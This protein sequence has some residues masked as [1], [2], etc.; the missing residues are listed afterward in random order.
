MDQKILRD[1][2]AKCIQ[3]EPPGCTAAC[4]VHVDARGLIKAVRKGDYAMG[5]S[6]LH[7]AVPFPR[8]ISRVCD[9]P[10]QTAC[11]RT[12]VDES[13]SVGYLERVCVEH[14]TA[15]AVKIVIPPLKSKKVAVV[16]AGL[17]GLTAA[18]ELARKGYGVTI[19]EATDRLGGSLRD[20]PEEKLPRD[21]IEK[22]FAI[23]AQLPV[24][25]HYNTVIGGRGGSLKSIG[26]LCQEFD[27]IY[28]GTGFAEAHNLGSG[29]APDDN[30]QMIIDTQTLATS[31]EKIFAG[32]SI[33]RGCGNRSPISSI[34]DG[35][36]ASVSIDRLLQDA[37][38]TAN[39]KREGSFKTLLY[40][41]IS[42]VEPQTRVLCAE[43]DRGYTMEEAV[44]EA[45]RCIHCECL[46]CVKVCEHLKHFGAYPKRYARE[47]Y[48]N[49][50]I[51]QGMHYANKMINTCSLCGLCEQICP[52]KLDMRE[53]YREARK[54]MVDTGKMPPS[55]HD[56]ALRDM[57]F[58]NSDLFALCR[59]Q[60]GFS[61]STAVFFPSCQLAASTPQHVKEVYAY[62]CGK[63]EGGVGLMLGCCGAPADWAGQEA[64]FRETLQNIHRNWR[65]LGG[66]LIITACPS[67]FAMFKNNIPDVPVETLWTVFDRIG[68]PEN[69]ECR[70]TPQTLAIHDSCTT[71]H[72]GQLHDAVRRMLKGLGHQLEELPG[73]RDNTTCCSYGG[74][75]LYAN[76]EVAHK[77]VDRRIKESETDYVA[78]CAMCRDSFAGQGKRAYHLLD[79][80]FGRDQDYCEQEPPGFSQRQENRAKL[81]T[82]LL[83]EIWGEEVK[84]R[85]SDVK[86]IIPD[87]VQRIMEDG[88]ILADDVTRVIA[89]A[90]STGNKLK[91]TENGHYIAYL[92]PLKVTYWVEYSPRSEGFMV[93]NAYS[94][95]LE[96]K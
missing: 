46:E 36:M 8:I 60:S 25:I 42:G 71:R 70:I 20:L 74:L 35:R 22:D 81:K 47:V 83:R 50:S 5:F 63:I 41:N 76:K 78:Y 12:E 95:R 54:M 56:F 91:N 37:S 18:L 65:D 45:T 53:I 87:N 32:G 34:C 79:L 15:P 21:L 68:L 17:S 11:K 72:E 51:V 2:E 31:E 64:L 3:E 38:L 14:H 59:H 67:C 55:T 52:G 33:R 85:Q 48:N 29:L 88:L 61:S 28:V 4:P 23:F 73:H 24:I 69:T 80:I 58:S 13:I 89:N 27:A 94:H 30:G 49:L 93:H 44:Q 84:E 86:V 16:G 90:E 92:Q 96:I 7:K 66:P 82:A 77:V 75:M 1:R 43:P 10:C 62:L 26:E 39:R 9:Q 57:H 19:F 6:L 40:T